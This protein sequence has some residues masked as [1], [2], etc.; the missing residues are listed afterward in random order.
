V[1]LPHVM[2]Q[3]GEDLDAARAKACDPSKVDLTNNVLTQQ[4]FQAIYACANY[5]HSLNGL[6]TL[7]NSPEFPQLLSSVN[8]I[9]KSN[10]AKSLYDTL[11]DWFEDG[12]GGQSKIDRL[13][14]FLASLIKN[15]AF[16]DFLPVFN[17]ILQSGRTVWADLLPGLADVVYTDLFPDN[18]EN[19]FVIFNTFSGNAGGS[20]VAARGDD[21]DY[22]KSVK[23]IARFLKM[24]VDGKTASRQALELADSLRDQQ[25]DGTSLY[26]FGE[27]MLEF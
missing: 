25:P 26:Q 4:N 14:P 16:Q 2:G 19:A 23:D 15:P 10:N 22:A 18:L 21:T 27:H 3:N 7:F 5:D 13:L 11:R 24:N 12:P 8:T 17:N 1:F 9:L 20:P 6:D